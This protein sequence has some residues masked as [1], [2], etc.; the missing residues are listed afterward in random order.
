MENKDDTF[1]FECEVSASGCDHKP[2][3][4]EIKAVRSSMRP[5]TLTVPEFKERI[6]S[7]HTVVP[8]RWGKANCAG[9]SAQIVVFDIDGSDVGMDEFVD[10]LDV[11]PS[12][13]YHTFS[14]GKVIKFRLVYIFG[15]PFPSECYGRLY[16][17][18]LNRNV[19]LLNVDNDTHNSVPYQPVFGTNR[20]VYGLGLV[21]D[22][23]D[24]IPEYVPGKQA[25]SGDAVSMRVKNDYA[26]SFWDDYRNMPFRQFYEKYKEVYGDIVIRETI[27]L[28]E[29]EDERIMYPIGP[30]YRIDVPWHGKGMYSKWKNGQ[31][32]H[33]KLY[34]TGVKFRIL[35]KQMNG[36]DL[37]R[38]FL[39]YL[40]VRELVLYYDNTDKKFVKFPMKGDRVAITTLVDNVMKASLDLEEDKGGKKYMVNVMY[41]KENDIPTRGLN[42]ILRN[43]RSILKRTLKKLDKYSEFDKYYDS[44][45]SIRQNVSNMKAHGIE[46]NVTAI[47]RYLKSK[48]A[49]NE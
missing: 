29:E 27:Y 31:N 26:S 16:Y 44:S 13:W 12:F 25:E 23:P 30:Y 9:R 24:F 42:A 33:G 3:G 48:E 1:V 37:D 7:G 41:C 46:T 8:C 6:G 38:E 11:Q 45:L 4:E 21:H 34:M 43:E 5:E 28:P 19:S 32:R 22:V 15:R 36:G 40:L 20:E 35:Y 17:W 39:T 18:L 49:D 10:G 2:Y 14:S 47:Q